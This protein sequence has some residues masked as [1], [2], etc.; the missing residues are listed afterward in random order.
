M[1]RI[2]FDRAFLLR[3]D[4]PINHLTSFYRSFPIARS[5]LLGHTLL[6]DLIELVA[7]LLHQQGHE[8]L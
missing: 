8:V 6:L 3:F 7:Q 1:D 2:V 4:I 5:P